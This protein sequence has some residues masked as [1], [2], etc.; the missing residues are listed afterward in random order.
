M[1]LSCKQPNEV[2][3]PEKLDEYE[4]MRDAV[5]DQLHWHR[6]T[7]FVLRK[8]TE[9]RF[10]VFLGVEQADFWFLVAR[11][12]RA[13]AIL[14]V[15]RMATDE[16]SEWLTISA[17][18]DFVRD[19]LRPGFLDEY[20]AQLKAHRFAKRHRA[21]LEKIRH[22][23]NAWLAHLR[24]TEALQGGV[25]S[26]HAVS[27]AEIETVSEELRALFDLLCFGYGHGT[28]PLDY[29]PCVRHPIASD[30]RCDIERL[31]DGLAKDSPLLNMPEQ[32]PAFWHDYRAGLSEQELDEVN[33]YRRKF[34][35]AP[36]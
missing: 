3:R 6:S 28:L 8:V 18:R 7:L 34:A 33:K 10:D 9:F 29:D 35:M 32:Q 20:Y 17:F 25:A 14:G 15:T 5:R 2:I 13:A 24:K 12:F 11:H 22:N 21:V 1:Q 4:K 16:G 27:L 23:R 36:A 30:P 19:A 31:L 26:S